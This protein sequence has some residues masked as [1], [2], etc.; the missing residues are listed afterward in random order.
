M[1]SDT[2]PGD[3][4]LNRTRPTAHP[5]HNGYKALPQAD[6]NQS[7]GVVCSQ[8]PPPGQALKGTSSFED[9]ALIIE[10]ILVSGIIIDRRQRSLDVAKVNELAASIQKIGLRTPIT[11]RI[12]H[13][14][15]GDDGRMCS[16]VPMLAT[17][18]HRLEAYRILGLDLSM[19]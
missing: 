4:F 19:R 5:R 10:E 2:H 16:E 13:D 15:L 6:L 14:I 8:N 9:I 17:G 3:A 7:N 11:V 12:V 18:R 1:R